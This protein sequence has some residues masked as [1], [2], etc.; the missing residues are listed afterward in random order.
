MDCQS[1][2][3]EVIHTHINASFS[4]LNIL[5]FEDRREKGTQE[6]MVISMATW[7]RRKFNQHLIQR[8]FEQL[9][10]DPKGKKV[11]QVYAELSSYGAI[12]A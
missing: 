10:I 12:A 7:K 9:G 11:M 2:K 8:V 6:E 3:K 1:R 5:K 4:A